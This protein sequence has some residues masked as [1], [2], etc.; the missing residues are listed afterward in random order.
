MVLEV[1]RKEGVT[2]A[3]VIAGEGER[4]GAD[5]VS[6]LGPVMMLAMLGTVM[7]ILLKMPERGE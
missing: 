7:S 5:W 6:L 3:T 4:E 1:D 2:V